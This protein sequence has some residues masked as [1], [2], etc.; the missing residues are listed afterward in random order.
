MGGGG[1]GQD[2]NLN[3]VSAQL[4][5]SIQALSSRMCPAAITKNEGRVPPAQPHETKIRQQVPNS[6]ETPALLGREVKN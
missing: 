1:C 6:S 4:T 5:G 3:V 2:S